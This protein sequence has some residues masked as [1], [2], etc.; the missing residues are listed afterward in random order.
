MKPS[1]VARVF[2]VAVVLSVGGGDAARIR[3]APAADEEGANPGPAGAA[4]PRHGRA[5]V[6]ALSRS[7]LSP[8]AVLETV[9]LLE[10]DH[11]FLLPGGFI[12]WK[13]PFTA[14]RKE[15]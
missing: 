14:S 15:K 12:G 7:A 9:R 1:M 11:K 4:V 8:G 6:A 5:V 10:T 2:L 13:S 3:P